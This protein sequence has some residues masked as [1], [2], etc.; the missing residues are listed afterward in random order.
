MIWRIDVNENLDEEQDKSM[1]MGVTM[2]MDNCVLSCTNIF[3]V[4]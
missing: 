2:D 3:R 4:S 1:N